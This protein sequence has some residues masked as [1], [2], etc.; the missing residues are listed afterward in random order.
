M[1]MISKPGYRGYSIWLNTANMT[2]E[3]DGAVGFKSLAALKAHVDAVYAKAGAER[4]ASPALAH[5]DSLDCDSRDRARRQF[6]NLPDAEYNAWPSVAE[7]LYA[8]AAEVANA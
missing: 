7:W 6:G 2:H 1:S 3:T 5:W 8:C 4:A